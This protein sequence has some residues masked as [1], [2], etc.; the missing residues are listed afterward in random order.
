M[1][2]R[3]QLTDFTF[4]SNFL[5][6]QYQDSFSKPTPDYRLCEGHTKTFQ[7]NSQYDIIGGHR[8][9]VTPVDQVFKILHL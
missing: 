1:N 2:Y 5:P 9:K 3:N 4:P 6:F 8:Q 7:Q